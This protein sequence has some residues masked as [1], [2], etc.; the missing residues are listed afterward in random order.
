MKKAWD[1]REAGDAW[2]K[3]NA[4]TSVDACEVDDHFPHFTM[5]DV[6]IALSC[7]R[8]FEFEYKDVRGF[9]QPSENGWSLCSVW[10]GEEQE[11]VNEDLDDFALYA[12]LGPY[13]FRDVVEKCNITW[14]A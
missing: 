2:Q 13:A 1:S 7:G 11:Y 14:L 6:Q 5:R 3:E 10:N 4:I 9:C 8:E 12:S